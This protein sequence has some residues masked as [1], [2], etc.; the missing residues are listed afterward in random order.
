METTNIYAIDNDDVNSQCL[1]FEE[2]D[3][4]LSLVLTRPETKIIQ[5]NFKPHAVR[6][7]CKKRGNVTEEIFPD[8]GYNGPPCNSFKELEEIVAKVREFFN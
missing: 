1:K 6:V 7:Q 2:G 3:W 4:Q 8:N 5:H